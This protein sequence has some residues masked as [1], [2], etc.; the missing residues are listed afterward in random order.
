M[1]GVQGQL[2]AWKFGGLE[3]WFDS[4]LFRRACWHV[5]DVPGVQ[6][7]LLPA[8]VWGQRPTFSNY[9]F[10]NQLISQLPFVSFVILCVLCDDFQSFWQC[11]SVF[12]C[13]TLCVS[14]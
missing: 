9:Q 6:G 11:F 10:S 2:E 13:E 7:E 1:P 5:A 3:A 8:G 4:A 14:L 12:L